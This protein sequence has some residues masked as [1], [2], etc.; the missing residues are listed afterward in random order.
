MDR[1]RKAKREGNE[2]TLQYQSPQET[3]L[4]EQEVAAKLVQL[5]AQI[6]QL[7]QT[8]DGLAVFERRVKAFGDCRRMKDESSS[9]YYERLRRWLDQEIPQTK[10]PRHPPRQTG[11]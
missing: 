1:S 6:E 5:Q 9:Q 10:L 4:V 3:R 7:N 2:V 8:P 11:G